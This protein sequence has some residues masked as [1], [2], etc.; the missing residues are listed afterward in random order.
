MG[1]FRPSG[2]PAVPCAGLVVLLGRVEAVKVTV[3][4]GMVKVDVRF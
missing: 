3:E 2:I 4:T 1:S